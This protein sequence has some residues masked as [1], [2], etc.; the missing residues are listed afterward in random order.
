MSDKLVILSSLIVK[1]VVGFE[2]LKD[3][4][5]SCLDFVILF[6]ELLQNLVVSNDEFYL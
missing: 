5:V 4:Y 2:L 1:V 3:E 6:A